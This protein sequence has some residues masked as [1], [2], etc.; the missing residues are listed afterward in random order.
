MQAGPNVLLWLKVE[1]A[2]RKPKLD[3]YRI[4]KDKIS[5]QVSAYYTMMHPLPH[6][7]EQKSELPMGSFTFR[8]V[9]IKTLDPPKG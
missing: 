3:S 4:E 9:S 6:L 2:D 8:E 1:H 5:R 7:R